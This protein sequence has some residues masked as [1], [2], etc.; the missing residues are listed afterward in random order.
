MNRRPH[1]VVSGPHE[2]QVFDRVVGVVSVLPPDSP[3]LGDR[4]VRLF[5]NLF[6]NEHPVFVVRALAVL[7]NVR[8]LHSEITVGVRLDRSHGQVIAWKLPGLELR[9]AH[10]PRVPAGAPQAFIVRSVAWLEPF[11]HARC[12]ESAAFFRIERRHERRVLAHTVADCGYV[13]FL[14][15]APELLRQV[16]SRYVGIQGP[17]LLDLHG[18]PELPHEFTSLLHLRSLRPAPS[19]AGLRD[20]RIR[21]RPSRPQP[22]A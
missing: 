21:R 12:A 10:T 1:H 14:N 9:L 7:G 18:R 3:T 8:D 6:V 2:L 22:R 19:G 11:S 13:G 16:R 5:P 4:P 17:Q 15:R 20:L